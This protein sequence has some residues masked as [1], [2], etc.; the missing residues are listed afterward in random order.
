MEIGSFLRDSFLRDKLKK[1]D[2]KNE[3]DDELAE[4]DE[5]D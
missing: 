5:N 4:F 2:N 3:S 1:P